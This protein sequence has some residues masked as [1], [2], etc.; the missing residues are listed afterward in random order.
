MLT[1]HPSG[2][3]IML[4]WHKLDAKRKLARRKANA[5]WMLIVTSIG[6]SV[7]QGGILR[8]KECKK[9]SSS[10]QG[11]K[12]PV[13]LRAARPVSSFFIS[14]YWSM[15]IWP[16]EAS[17]Q[18]SVKPG[19]D[20]LIIKPTIPPSL[21]PSVQKQTCKKLVCFWTWPRNVQYFPQNIQ[22]KI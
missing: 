21:S 13:I 20:N 3:M 12:S 10:G 18:K 16:R 11:S 22:Q 1:W 7:L 19:W 15:A 4:I 5:K 14:W 2:A 17:A 9:L 6:C 8:G